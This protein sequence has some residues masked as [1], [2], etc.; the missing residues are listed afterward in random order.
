MS[1]ANSLILFSKVTVFFVIFGS[2]DDPKY[3]S[4]WLVFVRDQSFLTNR[5]RKVDQV[6]IDGKNHSFTLM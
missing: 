2:K 4:T 5:T 6:N 3:F 1:F